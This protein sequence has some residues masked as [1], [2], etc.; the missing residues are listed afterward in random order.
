MG[1]EQVKRVNKL[2]NEHWDYV[3]NL[4]QVLGLSDEDKDTIAFVYVSA[5]EHGYKHGTEDYDFRERSA[6]HVSTST[7]SKKRRNR[8]AEQK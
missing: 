7:P 6:K 1:T 5:F 4:L 2:A 8:K 3:G